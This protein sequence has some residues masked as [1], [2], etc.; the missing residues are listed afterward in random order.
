MKT[1]LGHKSIKS[2]EKYIHLEKMFFNEL[3]ANQFIV[4]VAK[5]LKDAVKL[6]QVGFEFHCEIDDIKLFRKRK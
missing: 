4:K 2:T 3:E 1:I 5:T 6:V